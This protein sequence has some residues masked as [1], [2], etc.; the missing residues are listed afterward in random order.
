MQLE[1]SK[2]TKK[3]ITKQKKKERK[4]IICKQKKDSI[5]FDCFIYYI[6]IL[7]K[8]LHYKEQYLDQK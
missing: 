3:Y 8:N 2:L 1:K 6:D 5:P 7:K 4:L